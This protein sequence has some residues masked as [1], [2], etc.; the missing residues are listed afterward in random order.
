M[1]VVDAE[2]L[3]DDAVGEERTEGKWTNG[4]FNNDIKERD[5]CETLKMT[6]TRFHLEPMWAHH[7]LE[8]CG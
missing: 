6:R 3:D 5:G 8:M 4:T 1:D 2:R 7:T